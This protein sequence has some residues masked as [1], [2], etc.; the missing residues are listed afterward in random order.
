VLREKLLRRLRDMARGQ[1]HAPHVVEIADPSE[2]HP[3]LYWIED[4][5][6]RFL[7]PVTMLRMQGGFRF[8]PE[9]PFMRAL[10]FGPGE[11]TR[12]YAGFQPPDIAAMHG[13]EKTGCRGERLPPWEIPWQMRMAR[14][15][16]PGEAGLSPSHG[17][18][19]YGPASDAKVG[20]EMNRLATLR[21]SVEANGYQPDVFGD[22]E[23]HFLGSGAGLVFFVR[24]G[25]HR[26]A[27]LAALGEQKIPVRCRPTWP[28]IARSEDA[29]CWPLVVDGSMDVEFASRLMDVYVSGADHEF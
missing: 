25:K 22:I 26:A 20:V 5:P 10:R 6:L 9:H 28:R 16:P 4:R 21:S 18:S 23:G 3:W 11:L 19:F 13:M 27:V 29:P 14:A 1:K 15:A 2:V 24:G 12:F 17:V 7:L 8:G